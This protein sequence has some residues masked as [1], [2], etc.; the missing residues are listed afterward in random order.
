MG[1]DISAALSLGNLDFVDPDIAWVKNMQRQINNL[2]FLL[3]YLKAYEKAVKEEMGLIGGP[4]S[5]W[6]I[7]TYPKIK[8]LL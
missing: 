7:R 4:I 3:A 5:S 8:E 6:I 2:S 1:D